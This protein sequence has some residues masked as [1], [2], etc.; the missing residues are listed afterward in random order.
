[1]VPGWYSHSINVVEPLW[2]I[3]IAVGEMQKKWKKTEDMK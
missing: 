1:M 2:V 3:Q